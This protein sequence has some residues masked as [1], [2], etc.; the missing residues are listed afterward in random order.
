MKQTRIQSDAGTTFSIS[1]GTDDRVY[2]VVETECNGG[3]GAII[4]ARFSDD[5]AAQLGKAICAAAFDNE[6]AL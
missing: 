2:V 3:P 5:Q 6:S 1:R 4:S